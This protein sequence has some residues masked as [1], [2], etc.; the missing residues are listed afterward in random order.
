MRL[1][2]TAAGVRQGFRPYR[3][4]PMG[5]DQVSVHG[6]DDRVSHRHQAVCQR[7]ARMG[8]LRSHSRPVQEIE[9]RIAV[10]GLNRML[11]LGRPES[12]RA[13]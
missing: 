1:A 11:D 10:N 2:S 4:G 7:V 13:A 3:M 12:V 6:L 9:T 8:T 5:S